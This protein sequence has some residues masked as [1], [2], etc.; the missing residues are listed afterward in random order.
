MNKEERHRVNK[1]ETHR[2]NKEE[3]HRVNKEERHRVNKEERYLIT[4]KLADFRRENIRTPYVLTCI[5][6]L[7]FMISS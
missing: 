5:S 7:L 4:V 6:L 2:V 1:E 3:R